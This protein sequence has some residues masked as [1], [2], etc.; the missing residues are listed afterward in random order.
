[1]EV[2]YPPSQDLPSFSQNPPSFSKL[3]S[4]SLECTD[5]DSGEYGSVYSMDLCDSRKFGVFVSAK[6][7]KP[8]LEEDQDSNDFVKPVDNMFKS[9]N[10]GEASSS[11]SSSMKPTFLDKGKSIA[12][13]FPTKIKGILGAIP[14]I[15][16][17]RLKSTTLPT[18]LKTLKVKSKGKA[19]EPS[20][21]SKKVIGHHQTWY[22]DSGCSRH[23]THNNSIPINYVTEKG[24]PITFGD[25]SRGSTKGYG[26]L[27]NGFITFKK[28]S[29]VEGLMPNL[30]NISQLF[31]L[32][33]SMIFREHD[34]L[35]TDRHFHTVLSGF[36]KD[37]VYV[38]NMSYKSAEGESICF[39]SEDSEKKNWIWHKRLSHIKFKTLNAL[40]NKELVVGLPKISF[41][42]ENLCAAYAAHGSIWA[43]QHSKPRWKKKSEVINGQHVRSVRSDND[44]EFRNSTL[45]VFFNDK[46]ISQNFA[47]GRTPQQNGVVERKNKTLCEVARSM[48]SESNLPTYFWAEAFNTTC[49]TQNRSII[50]KRHNKTSYEVFYGR[51]SNISFLH[52]FGCVC[53][54]LNDREHLGKFYPKADERIFMGFSLTSKAYRVY[55]FRRKCIDESIHVKFDDQKSSSLSCDDNELYQWITYYVGEDYHYQ[56]STGSPSVKTRR[57]IGNIC[58]YVNFLSIIE[59]KNVEEA[60]ADP[61][62]I[63]AILEA[64]RIFLAHAAHKNFRVFQMDVKSAFLIGELVE[65]V[66]VKQPPGFEDP[67]HPD[68]VFKLDKALYGLKQAPH[69]WYDTLSDFLLSNRYTRGELTFFL[70]HQI[71]R[72]S[73]GNFINQSK[74]IRDLLK[75]FQFENCSPMKTPKAPPLKIHADPAGKPVDITIYRGMIG[76]LLYLI[77]SRP[78]IMYV[79]CLCARYQ[80]NHKESHLTAV[81]CIFRYLKGTMNMGLWYSKDSGFDPIGYSD[82]D[83]AGS[84]VDRKSITGSCQLL[85]GILVSWS[86][87]KQHSVSTSTAE[88]EYVAAGS[89]CAQILWMKNQLQDYDKFYSQVPILCDNSSAITIANNPMLHSRSMHIDIRYHFIR[90]HIS[91]GDI[92]LH[93]IPTDFRL[94]DLFTK[95]MNETRFNF[96]VGSLGKHINCRHF[97]KPLSPTEPFLHSVSAFILS[98]AENPDLSFG[99]E[100]VR[101]ILELPEYKPYAPFPTNR[102]HEEV[103]VAMNYTHDG[104]GKG[105]GLSSAR[106]WEAFGTSFSSHLIYCISHKTSGWDQSSAFVTHLAHA[107]MFMCQIDFAQVIFDSI[108]TVFSPLRTPIVA[109][110]IFLSLIINH[111][112]VG[113]LAA[114]AAFPEPTIL[115]DLLPNHLGKQV[116]HKALKATDNPLTTCMISF[117]SSPNPVWGVPIDIGAESPQHSQGHPKSVAPLPPSSS[118]AKSVAM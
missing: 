106:I 52:V 62:W 26:T 85:G 90:D 31:D 43:C 33:Y 45:D 9:L 5:S 87:K 78:D 86:S 68:Y 28:V 46:G 21:K 53:F 76:S 57:G 118:R 25:N 32:G 83:F 50:V 110:P 73:E 3:P 93:F 16:P 113:P 88:V 12:I 7:N 95:P 2:D 79:T 55:N 69:A 115:Y 29:Y 96:I 64:I 54:I 109:L 34:C 30:L 19:K 80:S 15:L 117:I 105:T 71:K 70:G 63:T 67:T 23:M 40:S 24:P 77:A 58:F 51:K 104:N 101:T 74:Y 107:L 81:K 102:E 60:L 4:Y 61:C 103:V 18:I 94:A 37:N 11:S 100:D 92:E 65:K 17:T 35:I 89:C 82:S 8:Q 10:F 1:M 114:D 42:K 49:F 27:S 13:D 91:K 99:V 39:I 38:I 20:Q 66:Y 75:K 116:L 6:Q 108:L 48:L 59:P 36:R 41:T 111:K 112:L 44:T 56:N 97:S 14:S 22:L 84:K 72:T 47:A 98:D